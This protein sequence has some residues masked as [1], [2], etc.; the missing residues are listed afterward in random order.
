MKKAPAKVASRIGYLELRPKQ[1][2]VLL[3]FVCG[4]DVFVILPTGSGKSLCYSLLTGV[5]NELHR[6]PG[7]SIVIVASP[8]VALMRD[9]MRAMIES[10]RM[11]CSTVNSVLV[12]T[13]KALWN[14]LAPEYVKALSTI[15]E[16]KANY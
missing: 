3:D 5:F 4:C 9:Q 6:L 15:E 11:G 13:C 1:E 7:L 12:E 8:L 2:E 14:A 16:W 10:N